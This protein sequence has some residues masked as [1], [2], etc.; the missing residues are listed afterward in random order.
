M[1]ANRYTT[2]SPNLELNDPQTGE[3]RVATKKLHLIS[4]IVPVPGLHLVIVSA[5][6]NPVILQ[7]YLVMVGG[8]QALADHLLGLTSLGQ[9][10]EAG[11]SPRSSSSS[12]TLRF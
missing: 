3:T 11:L 12:P 1:R 8:G 2:C 7:S 9:L 10:H 4:S 6:E 5:S